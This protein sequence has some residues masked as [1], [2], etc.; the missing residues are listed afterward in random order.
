MYAQ[1]DQKLTQ[2][3][4]LQRWAALL[5]EEGAPERCELDTY[6]EVLVTPPPSFAHQKIVRAIERQLEAALGGTAGSFAVLTD[7]GVFIPDVCWSADI[8]ALAAQ[9]A[10]PLARCPE[11]CVEVMFPGNRRR[12]I[13]EKVDAYLASGAREVIIVELDG[14]IR[15]LTSASEQPS[16]QFGVALALPD[17]TYPSTSR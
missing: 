2:D 13:N 1:L 3:Q 8:D 9:G 11:I 6:G 17:N 15:Y 12:D 4:L 5:S 14:R 10:D 16:S 7:A